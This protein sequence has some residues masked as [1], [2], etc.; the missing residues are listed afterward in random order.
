MRRMGACSSDPDAVRT[1]F[2]S[3]AI[4][5]WVRTSRIVSGVVMVG[6]SW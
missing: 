1:G 5:G 2:A 3:G 4:T 6:S